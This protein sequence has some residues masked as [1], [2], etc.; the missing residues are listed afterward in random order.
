M[1]EVLIGSYILFGLGLLV[2]AGLAVVYLSLRLRDARA[3]QPDPELGIKSAYHAFLT[4]GILLALTGLSISAIDL[5]GDAFEGD[6][7]VQ[8]QPQFNPQFNPRF[9]QPQPQVRPANDPFDTVSQRVA[10]P[11]VISGVLFSLVALLLLRL[12]T[13]DPH[14]PSARRAF[15]GLRLVVGG[16]TVMSAVTLIIELLFQKDLGTTRPYAIGVGLLAIWFPASAVQ[17]FL[18]K[19]LVGLPYYVPPRPKKSKARR[20]EDDEDDRDDEPRRKPGR[21]RPDAPEESGPHPDDDPRPPEPRRPRPR[22][23]DEEGD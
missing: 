4:T 12:G 9:P 7:P 14:Y 22:P 17:L 18:L 19:R 11:L 5:L 1:L 3:E 23:D 21:R 6:K 16:F 15:G 8:Q 13:N 10:W 2:L 20:W